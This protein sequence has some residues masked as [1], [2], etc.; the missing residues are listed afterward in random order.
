MHPVLLDLHLPLLGDTVFPSYFT[1][2]LIGFALAIVLAVRE[3]RRLGLDD[4]RVL[5]LGLWMLFWGFVGA[6]VFHLLFDG[7]LMEYVHLCTDP[8]QVPATDALTSSCTQA[9]QCGYDYLCNTATHTCYPPQ[10]CLRA[11]KV[12]YGGLVYYGGLIFAMGFAVYYLRRHKLPFAR[13]ADITAPGIAF[14][15][16]FGRIGCWL[17]GCCFG[18]V[19]TAAAGVVFPRGSDAWRK[20]VDE[21][22]IT[23][24]MSPL[25]VIPTELYE[26]AGCLIL[27][28]LLVLWVKPR[29]RKD[30]EVLGALLAGYAVLRFVLE[31]FRDDDRGVFLHGLLSTSQIVSLPLFGLGLYLLFRPPGRP[32][33]ALTSPAPTGP[34]LAAS[35]ETRA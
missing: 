15:L 34:T 6:R 11:F 7:H 32:P 8:T 26:A 14:G 28:L 27:F 17:N 18:R 25:P 20:Q 13:T 10:D 2:V 29:K 21:G 1:L 5:D 31:I 19:T 22:L 24:A 35:S 12:W 33:G 3:A 4:E 30:G 16:T 23:K 9:A